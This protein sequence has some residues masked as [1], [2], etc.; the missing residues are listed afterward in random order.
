ML[1]TKE[2]KRRYLLVLKNKAAQAGGGYERRLLN[3]L[4]DNGHP[5]R[6][7]EPPACIVD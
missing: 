6:L 2:S 7:P 5:E 1:N 3:T 4:P